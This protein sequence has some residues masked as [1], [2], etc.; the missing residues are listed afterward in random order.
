[1]PLRLAWRPSILLQIALAA[2]GFCA[3]IALWLSE[4][5]MIAT[6]CAM[7][8]VVAA[9]LH[10]IALERRAPVRALVIDAAGAAHLDGVVL[11]TPQLEWRGPLAILCWR[12]GRRVR[13]LLWW[14]DTLPP[15]AR[16]ELRLA[17]S[18]L[19][20]RPTPDSMAP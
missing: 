8:L 13:R 14:P 18:A 5:P 4:L 20:T 2:I 3:C 17:A 10:R 6:V 15:P 9:T 12:D 16:R 19:V 7:P 11:D 1:M